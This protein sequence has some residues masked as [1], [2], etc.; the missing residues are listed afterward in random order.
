MK[1]VIDGK[2]CECERGEFI[3][4]IAKRNNIYIPT[5]CHSDA[6]AG[7]GSCRLCM[8]EV[9][10]RGRA[11]VVTACLFPV[12]KEVEV[13]TNS[14]KIKRMRKNIIML[15]QARC[16][17]NEEVAKMADAFGVERKRVE[18]FKLDNTEN[19]VLCGLCTKACKEIG[20]GAIS[21][22][23]RGIYKKVE[24]PYE[25]PSPE[26]I[27]CGSCANVCPTNAIKI[28]DKDG[29]RE[30]WGKKFKLVQCDCCGANFATEEHIKFAY[31]KTGRELEMDKVLCEK[32]RRKSSLEEIKNMYETLNP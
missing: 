21:T 31:E 30:I 3:L 5:L 23:D 16:P 26:C 28:I 29:Q 22:V 12:S 7:L 11:K 1:I 27:G 17:E 13:V 8:V 9:V 32:C 14:E 10:D 2:S 4:Q 18:R 6:L 25:E 20:A 15:L 19:C 24:T